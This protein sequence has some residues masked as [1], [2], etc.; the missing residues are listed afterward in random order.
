MLPGDTSLITSP[1]KVK[2]VVNGGARAAR[3]GPVEINKLTATELR[4]LW[5]K[6]TGLP[7]GKHWVGFSQLKQLPLGFLW[8]VKWP[9]FIKKNKCWTRVKLSQFDQTIR[10]GVGRSEITLAPYS[11]VTCL[12]RKVIAATYLLV[13]H[14]IHQFI[15]SCPWSRMHSL[16]YSF[17]P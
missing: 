6:I 4:F 7:R 15:L 17:T 11:D 13:S 14:L 1:L 16:P 10:D 9:R 3:G 8:P 12:L 2:A 5:R